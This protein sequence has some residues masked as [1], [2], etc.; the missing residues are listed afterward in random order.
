MLEQEKKK[1]PWIERGIFIAIILLLGW[2][3]NQERNDRKES[4]GFISALNA[5]MDTLTNA[6]GE[7]VAK[8]ESFESRQTEAFTQLKINDSATKE[9]QKTVKENNKYLRKQ[10]SVTNFESESKVET[11]NPTEIVF[12][13][14]DSLPTYDSKFNL[15]GWV[16]GDISAGPDTTALSLTYWDRYSV[17]VGREPTGFLGLGEGKPFAKITSS[18]PYNKIKTMK[19]FQ[20]SVE[21]QPA[22]NYGIIGGYGGVFNDGQFKTGFIIGGGLSWRPRF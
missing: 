15:D 10:G 21:P 8:M 3:Y 1:S 16:Y 19:T 2:L 12:K 13:E 14:N 9:L 6:Q 5:K 17:V 4:E 11:T 18:N 22:F 20:V 7:F